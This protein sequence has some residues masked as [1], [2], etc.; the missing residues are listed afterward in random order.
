M[1]ALKACAI[2]LTRM[3]SVVSVTDLY[4]FVHSFICIVHCSFALAGK[5]C[6]Y[7]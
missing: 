1:K 3:W 2:Q 5:I 4:E 6:F 7:S